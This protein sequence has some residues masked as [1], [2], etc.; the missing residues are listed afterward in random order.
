MS[1]FLIEELSH[2]I[3]RI[4]D[5]QARTNTSLESRIKELQDENKEVRNRLTVLTRLLIA[6]QI[7]TAE[8]SAT[9]LAASL[10]PPPKPDELGSTPAV[11]EVASVEV[12]AA[13]EQPPEVAPE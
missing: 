7:A 4:R 2:R 10:A 6:R 9:A 12:Q 3:N 1:N 5:D 13:A 11:A 8:E